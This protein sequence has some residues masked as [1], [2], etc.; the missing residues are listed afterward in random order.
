MSDTFSNLKEENH[1]LKKQVAE[2][3]EKIHKMT[4][5]VT[6]INQLEQ[7]NTGVVSLDVPHQ[8]TTQ[9]PSHESDEMSL[10]TSSQTPSTNSTDVDI[11]PTPMTQ[12]PS[13]Q[14]DQ[15]SQAPVS[16]ASDAEIVLLMDS[17]GKKIDPQHLFPN[18]Q[19]IYKQSEH[20]SGHTPP[21]PPEGSSMLT[22]SLDGNPFIHSKK[23][24]L[25]AS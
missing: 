12:A 1:S 19:V 8:L 13:R 23:V 21:C 9:L 7:G 14:D 15:E 5:L 10:T 3:T 25:H 22:K 20:E 16:N 17:N 4:H 18:K 24:S 2:L 6:Q 11:C